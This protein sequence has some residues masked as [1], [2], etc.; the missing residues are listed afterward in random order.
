MKFN[1]WIW[2]ELI[3]EGAVHNFQ[4]Q[5]NESIITLNYTHQTN[6]Q[7]QCYRISSIKKLKFFHFEHLLSHFRNDHTFPPSSHRPLFPLLQRTTP[8]NT[9]RHNNVVFMV[10]CSKKGK[11]TFLALFI[12]RSHL[13]WASVL[14]VLHCLEHLMDRNVE[15]HSEGV[16][17]GNMAN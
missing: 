15:M 17:S 5:L 16:W 8:N 6:D 13:L 2:P 4:K 1:V 10:F 11:W 14:A 3:S 7:I 9:G 12:P